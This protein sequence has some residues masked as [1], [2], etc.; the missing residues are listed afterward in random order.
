M[1][2]VYINGK[3]AYETWGITLDESS[4]TSLMTPSP[5]KE[6]IKNSSRVSDG[7]IIAPY[8]KINERELTVILNFSAASDEEFLQKYQSFCSVLYKGD[9]EIRTSKIP[10]TVYHMLYVSCSEFQQWMFGIAKYQLKLI[11][12]NPANRV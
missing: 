4:L 12:P 9:L 7:S 3:D 1:T 11:E 8:R 2:E 10:G 5:M 6:Y